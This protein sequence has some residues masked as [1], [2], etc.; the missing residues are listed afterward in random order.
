MWM[1]VHLQTNEGGSSVHV[2][3]ISHQKMEQTIM[4]S[5]SDVMRISCARQGREVYKKSM[6]GPQGCCCCHLG[7]P[8]QSIWV[9]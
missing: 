3:W 8:V 4:T 1:L 7:V 5:H 9:H 2:Q 6:T